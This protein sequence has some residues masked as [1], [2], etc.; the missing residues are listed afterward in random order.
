MI[1]LLAILFVSVTLAV[2]PRTSHLV[3]GHVEGGRLI[4]IF[5]TEGEGVISFPTCER[6]FTTFACH[7]TSTDTVMPVIDFA[8]ALDP[9]C[10][11]KPARVVYQIGDGSPLVAEVGATAPKLECVYLPA[12]M[13]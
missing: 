11:P 2:P 13:R 12:V 8:V 5:V 10:Q 6:D 9:M 7:A 1:N 4:G 3:T